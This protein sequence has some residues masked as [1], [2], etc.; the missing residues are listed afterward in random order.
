MSNSESSNG[1]G[2]AFASALLRILGILFI[3]AVIVSCIPLTVPG[4]F[5]YGVYN[6]E[7]G[8]MAPE[9]PTGSVI[10]VKQVAPEEI[11]A[12]DVITF[13]NEGGTITHRVLSNKII[14]GEFITKGDANE[15]E[16][17]EPVPYSALVGKVTFHLPVL[18]RFLIVYSSFIGKIYVLI[19]A[20]CGVMMNILAG[21]IRGK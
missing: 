15:K 17:L 2:R 6:V 14:E 7:S 20:A 10:Y 16:D 11:A 4:L 5:G 3:A 9:I 8:S 21:R 1:K 19:F 12:G 18:G 13:Q